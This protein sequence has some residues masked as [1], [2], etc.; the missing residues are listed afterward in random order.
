MNKLFKDIIKAAIM[1][2]V[3]PAA[4]L[5]IVMAASEDPPVSPP[6]ESTSTQTKPSEPTQQT[7]PTQPTVLPTEP[8]K[9]EVAVLIDGEVVSM[10]L[11][12]YVVGV[13]L[14]EMPSSFQPEALKAQAVAARTY[15]L[16]VCSGGRHDGAVCIHYSCCQTYFSPE[17]FLANGG[18]PEALEKIRWAVE[19]TAG[20]VL[21]YNGR[22]ITATYFSCSGGST[23]DAV[24]VWGTEIPYL[25][26]V[27]SPGEEFAAV[28]KDT[29]TFTPEAFQ[30]ALCTRLDGDPDTW[31]GNVT[32]TEGGG[33]ATMEIGGV[34][35]R[36]TT[37][38]TLLGLRSTV[39]SVSVADGVI[40]IATLGYGHRVGMSQYGAE[41]MAQSGFN[42]SQILA[43]YYTGASLSDYPLD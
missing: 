41:A 12:D 32:Y 39:F 5:C 2:F 25:Q 35:Y 9:L 26:S 21:T 34:A 11:E 6:E 13:V 30:S 42:Y 40:R 8:Q 18:K 23:E 36:G 16:C 15:A 27:E 24:A 43:H 19:N 33:V 31:F 37:L 14:G 7:K 22:L 28:Y 3:V 29:Y 4:M 20:Q 1:G 38:R 10:E 17:S